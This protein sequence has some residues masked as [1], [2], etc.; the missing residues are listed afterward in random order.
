M[1]K[2]KEYKYMASWIEKDI[3]TNNILELP[4]NPIWIYWDGVTKKG[5]IPPRRVMILSTGLIY[6]WEDFEKVR[7]K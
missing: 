7:I 1:K 2:V 4:D 5:Q 3:V 6:T